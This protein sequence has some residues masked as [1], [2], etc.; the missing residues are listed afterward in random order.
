MQ[1]EA[2]E[3]LCASGAHSY[4]LGSELPY[5]LRWAEQQVATTGLVVFT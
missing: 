2:I 3:L 5:K 1:A 4:D